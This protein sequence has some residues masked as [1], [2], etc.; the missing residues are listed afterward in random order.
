[1]S[2]SP[3]PVT[4]TINEEDNQQASN[5]V[6]V[7]VSKSC[8]LAWCIGRPYHFQELPDE[9]YPYFGLS[10][11]ISYD[12]TVMGR[13]CVD[14]SGSPVSPPGARS[15]GGSSLGVSSE[16]EEALQCDGEDDEGEPL[17]RNTLSAAST[18]ETTT[19]G[20]DDDDNE[21][22]ANSSDSKYRKKKYEDNES[23][24][25]LEMKAI[26]CTTTTC[27]TICDKKNDINIVEGLEGI[28]TTSMAAVFFETSGSSV[29]TEEDDVLTEKDL[30]TEEETTSSII[31]TN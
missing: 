24:K 3:V 5:K 1:M 8:S 25:L 16:W 14:E 9:Y 12:P 15:E 6:A 29:S 7:W 11:E 21:Q 13:N 10:S 26:V 22:D 4:T 31:V 20:D 23:D 28:S 17:R 19:A 30:M 27:T 18:S 2:S